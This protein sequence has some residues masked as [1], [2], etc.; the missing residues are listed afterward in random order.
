[1]PFAVSMILLIVG[2]MTAFW[3]RPDRQLG[4]DTVPARLILAPN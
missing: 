2:A 1:M 4:T 3:I